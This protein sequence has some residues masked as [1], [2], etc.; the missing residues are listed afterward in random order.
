MLRRPISLYFAVSAQPRQQIDH[1][2]C[3]QN[4]MKIAEKTESFP[5]LA[6]C[7]SCYGMDSGAR[8]W[9]GKEET[10]FGNGRRDAGA[11]EFNFGIR[12]FDLDET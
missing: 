11:A 2:L 8:K 1:T 5:M 12:L 4:D 9:E 7:L 10:R 3:S 6:D